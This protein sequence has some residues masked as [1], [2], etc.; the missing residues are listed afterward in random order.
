MDTE[1]ACLSAR[2]DVSITAEIGFREIVKVGVN[3]RKDL[4]VEFREIN[5][6]STGLLQACLKLELEAYLLLQVL[7][8]R[9]VFH[10]QVLQEIVVHIKMLAIEESMSVWSRCKVKAQARRV[11]ALL[12]QVAIRASQDLVEIGLNDVREVRLASTKGLRHA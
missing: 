6:Q 8:L 9:T 5:L 1:A 7:Q 10:L 2:E 4:V 12:V 11:G 3:C